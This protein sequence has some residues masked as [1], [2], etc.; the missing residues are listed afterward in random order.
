MDKRALIGIALSILVLVIY[1][2]VVT[3]YYGPP[4]GTTPPAVETAPTEGKKEMIVPPASAVAPAPAAQARPP[5]APGMAAKDIR[6][7][8]DNYVTIFTTQGARLKSFKLKHFRS[9]VDV[10]S[11]PYDMVQTA[12]G[13][14]L[15]LG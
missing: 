6:V 13:V 8:T 3:R 10:N 4:P 7:E 1:Q 2:E 11:P 14:P 12:P 15:P 9:A 5:A